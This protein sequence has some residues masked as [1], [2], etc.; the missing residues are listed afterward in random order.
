MLEIRIF[1]K[2]FLNNGDLKVLYQNTIVWNKEIQFPFN[3][4]YESLR[5]LY[6]A[7]NVIIEFSVL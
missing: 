4:M 2:R 5:M 7:D 3:S 1:V 6:P